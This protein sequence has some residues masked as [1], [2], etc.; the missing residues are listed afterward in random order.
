[1]GLRGLEISNAHQLPANLLADVAIPEF[2]SPQLVPVEP[3]INACRA[4]RCCDRLS[5]SG[6]L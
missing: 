1:M 4:Q 3:H 5:R 6:V 2:G